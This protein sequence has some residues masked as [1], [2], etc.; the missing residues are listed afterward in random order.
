MIAFLFVGAAAGVLGGFFG[1]GGGII[2]VPF[3]I[4]IYSMIGVPAFLQ[5][6]MAVGTSLLTTACTTFA[7]AHAHSK[8]KVVMWELIYKIA[9]GVIF[10]ALLGAFFGRMIPSSALEIVFGGVLCALAVYL[11]FFVKQVE[12][13]T[14]RIPGFIVFNLV[15]LGVG[16]L[17]AMLGVSG[18][19]MMVP[20]LLFCHLSIRH[21][22]GT[23]SAVGFMISSVGAIGYLFPGLDHMS[24][25][26]TLGYL[27]LPAFI[28]MAIGTV[29]TARVGAFLA[30]KMPMKIL[31]KIFAVLLFIIGILMMA[32]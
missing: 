5:M 17:S 19:F 14:G 22:I 21:A 29:T 32:T 10:G 8:H 30:H 31:K 6:K 16:T 11:F 7:S 26:Y 28:P 9:V 12:H 23:A 2:F 3:Q 4:L 18:G 15:G 1:V 25:Q 13:E 27:Y 24:Y 20:I